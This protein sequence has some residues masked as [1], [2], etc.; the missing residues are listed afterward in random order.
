MGKKVVK[1]ESELQVVISHV[2]IVTVGEGVGGT[3]LSPWSVVE[4]QVEILQENDI[5]GLEHI[6]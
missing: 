3:H 1:E 2:D 4:M 5:T 6:P